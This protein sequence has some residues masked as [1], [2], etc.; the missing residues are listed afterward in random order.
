MSNGFIFCK[1][2]DKDFKGEAPK[3]PCAKEELVIIRDISGEDDLKICQA[4]AN[5]AIIDWVDKNT[6]YAPL[7]NKPFNFRKIL[8]KIR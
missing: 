7:Y 2:K 5:Q 6:T 1:N 8:K 3:C 4:R